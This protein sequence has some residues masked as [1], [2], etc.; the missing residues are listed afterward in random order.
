MKK[1][2]IY[3]FDKITKI[4]SQLGEI[5]SNFNMSF[6][7][8]GTKDSCSVI[9]WSKSGIEI[10]PY[11]ILLHLKTNTWWIVSHDKV[12]RYQNE[13]S[14]FVYVHELELL[15]AIE[16]LNAR[17]L[18]DC[19]FNDNT[20]TVSQFISRLFSLSSFE[21]SFDYSQNTSNNFLE[22]NVDFIKTYENYTL[23]SALREFLDAYNSSVKMTFNAS[24]DEGNNTYQI[25]NATLDIIPKTGN[26]NIVHQ[27]NDFDDV[28][29]TKTMDKNSFGTC[30][31]S[32]AENVISSKE[33]IYPSLGGAKLS[34][35]EVTIKPSNAIL[36]LPSKVFSA[37]W[38]KL[39]YYLGM[40]LHIDYGNNSR[41]FTFGFRADIA[42]SME[43]M[44]DSFYKGIKSYYSQEWADS[45]LND[46][47]NYKD[48]INEQL[49]LAG[50]ITFY[51]GNKIIPYFGQSDN[52]TGSIIIEKGD[53][54]PYLA[55]FHGISGLSTFNRP[56]VFIDKNSRELLQRK[57]QGIAWERGSNEITGFDLFDNAASIEDLRYTDL[58]Q[59]IKQ[60][61]SG[62]LGT[63]ATVTLRV[64]QLGFDPNDVLDI[65]GHPYNNGDLQLIA[66]KVCYIP[67][68]DIKIKVDNNRDKKDIQLYNQNGK[69]TDNVALSKLLNSYSKEISSDSITRYMHYYSIDDVPHVGDIVLDDNTEYVIN[70]VSMTFSQSETENNNSFNYFIECEISMSKYVSTKS[71]MVNPNTNIRDY[72]IPQNYNI[73]RKQLYR[74]FYEIN[75]NL[76]DDNQANYYFDP[77]NIFNFGHYS[78]DLIDFIGIL[79]LGYKEP[80]ESQDYWYYQLETTT[81]YMNKMLYVLLDFQDN[82]IIGYGSQN[83]FSGFVIS[84]IFQGLT[85]ELNTPISYVD[86][87]GMVESIEIKLCSKDEI[88]DVYSNYQDTVSGG[89]YA[90]V[91]KTLYNYS[92][93][94]PQEIY[95]SASEQ[96]FIEETSYNKDALEVPV[97]EYACQIDDTDD[98]LVGDNVLTQY[99]G[100]IVYFYSF[101]VGNNLTQANTIN[102]NT[103]RATTHPIGW[104]IGQGVSIDYES[105]TSDIKLLRIRLY[106]WQRWDIDELGFTNGPATDISQYEGKDIAIFRTAFDLGKG[107]VVADDLLFIAKKVPFTNVSQD[108]LILTLQ[109]N[110]YKLN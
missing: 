96:I 45:W 82:N 76:N 32:N 41:T 72:G 36:R 46:F 65:F 44:I 37:K 50:T 63:S 11:T 34:S 102:I 12:E 105:Y 7:I 79:K 17:D 10:E 53:N 42:N 60:F 85:D 9:V 64:S 90:N 48:S 89:Q 59:D 95:D 88:A 80:V 55:H 68:N 30:V 110:H 98:V 57:W 31:I 107:Q 3:A 24:Y 18:T 43:R 108:G 47:N 62:G 23:L 109:L 83:V 71:L 75:Y 4:G 99:E 69:I 16:L 49:K 103:I 13:D 1:D 73:K 101:V 25:L 91:N 104:T 27:M 100:N 40:S 77:S 51:E 86:D 15:G 14:T 84:R 58:Q 28:R 2:L 81:Y 78:N 33:K 38:L 106:N 93:F 94:I 26:A 56:V 20:Y 5:Q 67:M 35:T 19:G 61:Y 66:F 52:S 87:K 97:F 92:V 21:Y 29:E 74:D 39:Y 70:N 22:R 6:V 54:V 8:D